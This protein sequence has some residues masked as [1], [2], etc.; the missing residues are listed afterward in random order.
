MLRHKNQ[1]V[2]AAVQFDLGPAAAAPMKKHG[3]ADPL[4]AHIRPY[5]RHR[6]RRYLYIAASL[7]L[8]FL[9]WRWLYP[10]NGGTT[11]GGRPLGYRDELMSREFPAQPPTNTVRVELFVESQCP[12]TSRFIRKQLKTTWDALSNTGRIEL[13][14]VPFGKARCVPRGNDFDCSCQH[15][16]TECLIN[17]LMNCVI[18]RVGF[19]NKYVETV[20]CMQGTHSL[21]EA[22]KC[23]EGHPSLDQP[24]MRDC[25]TGERGRRLLALSG[26]RTA[27]LQPALDFVPWIL[28]DG[29]RNTD[30]LYDLAQNVCNVLHPP[31][32]ECSP[33]LTTAL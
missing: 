18:D 21:D 2:E 17:Q 28:I 24:R 25:A 29:V 3:T 19:P 27:G 10:G 33:F 5:S 8:L 15:G 26:Q 22:L 23:V 31:P 20:I 30:A 7:L 9:V 1:L 13:S 11:Y 12:D 6:V 4:L 32:A 16:P 14:V